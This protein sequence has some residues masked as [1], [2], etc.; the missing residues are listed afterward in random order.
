MK[1]VFDVQTWIDEFGEDSLS[2]DELQEYLDFIVQAVKRYNPERYSE[3]H[4]VM[5][6]CVDKEK[7]YR[8]QGVKINGRD[9]LSAHT[10]LIK[11]FGSNSFRRSLGYALCRMR[12]DPHGLRKLAPSDYEELREK[13]SEAVRG[14]KMSESA[15]RKIRKTLSDGRLKGANHPMYGKHHSEET[16]KKISE[17]LVQAWIVEK[18]KEF[19]ER[20][21]GKGNPCYGKKFPSRPSVSEETRQKQSQS[22]TGKVWI[23]NGEISTKIRED[24]ETPEGWTA[25]RLYFTRSSN[26]QEGKVWINNGIV[27]RKILRGSDLLEGFVYGRVK[28][29]HEN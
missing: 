2:L 7:K 11:C 28:K 13:F 6:K 15:C 20:R 1:S 24:Q 5:P 27:N 19:S 3:W 14:T 18:R 16:S 4:H 26:G 21:K 29:S 10:K 17:I 9:H 8:D 25:G 22:G 23:N 12:Q